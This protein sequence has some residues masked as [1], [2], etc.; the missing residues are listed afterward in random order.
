MFQQK[1]G[2]NKIVLVVIA[3]VITLV[4]AALV[5]FLAIPR[6][7]KVYEARDNFEEQ[8]LRFDIIKK[9]TLKSREYAE[10]IA[11]LKEEQNLL[12]KA[13][14]Q[15]D[16]EVGFI[17]EIEGVAD[18]VGNSV[19]IDYIPYVKKKVAPSVFADQA[20]L[21]KQEQEEELEKKKVKLKLEVK[22][23]YQQFLQ[24]FYRLENLP[25]VFYVDSIYVVG[26]GQQQEGQLVQKGEEKLSSDHTTT[27]IKIHFTPK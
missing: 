12:E 23:N 15:K 14:I 24:F 1:E 9:D 7:K 11:N 2:D 16:N 5:F 13:L 17:E 18:Q 10:L 25:F 8:K 20:T 4:V 19:K 26:S 22:G 6:A 27:E 21:E 3:L